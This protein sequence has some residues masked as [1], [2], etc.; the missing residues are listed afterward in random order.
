MRN[1]RCS[2]RDYVLSPAS[3]GCTILNQVTDHGILGQ[4]ESIFL[5]IE[6]F[7]KFVCHIYNVLRTCPGILPD[8]SREMKGR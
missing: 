8:F 4:L 3:I 5:N 6:G 1:E 7:Y 2:S